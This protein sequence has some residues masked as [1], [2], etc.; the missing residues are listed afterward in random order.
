MEICQ[1]MST[2]TV[3]VVGTFWILDEN[4]ELNN[5]SKIGQNRPLGKIGGKV[6]GTAFKKEGKLKTFL[7]SILSKTCI[8]YKLLKT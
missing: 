2:A 4:C 8:L 6:G 7:L 3:N 1:K 5:I